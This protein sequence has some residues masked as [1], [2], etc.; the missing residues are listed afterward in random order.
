MAIGGCFEGVVMSDLRGND[1]FH[2]HDYRGIRDRD[3]SIFGGYGERA[4][5]A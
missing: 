1:Y 3:G 5:H 4:G 2:Y